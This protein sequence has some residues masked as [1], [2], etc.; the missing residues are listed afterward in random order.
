[1]KTFTVEIDAQGNVKTT[2]KGFEADSPKLAAIVEAAAGGKVGKVDWNPKAHA[3][4][5]DGK[6]IT[7]TH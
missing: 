3:H 4:V 5:V 7:H 1:M 2:L 6:K